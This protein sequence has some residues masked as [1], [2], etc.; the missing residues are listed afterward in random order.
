MCWVPNDEKI[1]VLDHGNTQ[2]RPSLTA[3]MEAQIDEPL[4]A[5]MQAVCRGK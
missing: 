4:G 3:D 1:I 2:Q 5:S